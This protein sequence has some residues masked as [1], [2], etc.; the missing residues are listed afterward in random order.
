[1]FR[2]VF[3]VYDFLFLVMDSNSIS[4]VE[5]LLLYIILFLDQKIIHV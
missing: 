2:Y 3:C 4:M 1:M 5:F